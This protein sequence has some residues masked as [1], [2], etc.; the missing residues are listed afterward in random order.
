MMPKSIA[1]VIGKNTRQQ[2]MKG[3]HVVKFSVF[4]LIH[5]VVYFI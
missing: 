3:L 5:R 2:E 4:G 1:I